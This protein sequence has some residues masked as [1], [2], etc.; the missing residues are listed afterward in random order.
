[1]FKKNQ[2]A[3]LIGATLASPMAYVN[4]QDVAVNATEVD[5]SMVVTGK[6]SSYKADSNTGSMRMEMT[7]LETPGQVTVID[8][9]LI[10]EQR[11]STLGQVLKND[12]SISAQ[13]NSRNRER[14]T[15]RGFELGS[16]SGFLRD[17]KQHWSHYRQPI[18]LLESVEVL[19]GPAG[20]LYGKS[21][22][23]GLINMV[24][25]KPTAETQM[26]FSQDIG[27]NNETRSTLDISGSLNESQSLRSRLVLS[28][29]D[30]ESSRS[31]SDGS[32]PKTDRFVGGLFVDYDLTDDIMLSVH[33]D[34]TIDDSSVDSGA[35]IKGGD[36]VLG[37]DYIWDAQ[38]SNIKNEVE[39]IGFDVA[40]DLS[41]NWS[42]NFS[43]NHQDFKRHD[44]ESYP[45][46]ES[47]DAATGTYQHSGNDRS[48]HWVF[49]TAN[50]DLI[51][52]FE[53]AGLDH[54]LLIGTNWLGYSYDMLRYSFN[55]ISTTVEQ[56]TASPEIN[57]AKD[58]R[59]YK[60]ESDSFGLYIQDMLT[61]NDQ[62]QVLAG[63]RYDQNIS[64]GQNGEEDYKE[65]AIVPK[66]AVIYHPASNGSIY[67][68]YSESFEPQGKVTNDKANNFDEK[69]D[70]KLGRLYELGSKWE[71]FD[72][73]LFA[74]GAI[75]EIT[76]ENSLITKDLGNDMVEVT[77]AGE[78]VHRG[79]E[80]AL[81]GYLT[82]SLSLSGSG[83]YL[84][85]EY[86]KDE[87]Y[88]GNRPADVPEF[89]ASIWSRYEFANN[90]DV[91]LGAIYVGSRFGDNANT[92]KKDA[93]T[94]FDLG[95]AHTLQYDQNLEFTVRL[96]V[97]NVFDTGYYAGGGSTGRG[98]G[99]YAKNG[100]QNVVLGEG[101]NFMATFQ[102]RY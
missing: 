15:L 13:G 24:S 32:S 10:N 5:E 86:T 72:E 88:Q 29:Q 75:F 47:Y 37:D 82:E 56:P 83:T 74:S 27:S 6:N 85:A 7:Q 26:E 77:Q 21:A 18:E 22:P 45:K 69:L 99:G 80:L 48:D 11:A 50:I 102:V 36:V 59:I 94:R 14:F 49:Q 40:A 52:E 43:F 38:W 20:L 78:R 17:G 55:P 71:L 3:L 34:K 63:L 67:V 79:A 9:Q 4:A 73:K 100:A 90:T 97:E 42:L 65:D 39:N 53:T 33:Y 44:V 101:R 35:Y 8:E 60:S 1:M 93:Y 46:E 87:N 16:S 84:D 41:T 23:G 12:S 25:K 57:T 68:T 51:G 76:Q 54:Q 19:K 92:F 98:D 89:S 28:K 95:V 2:L 62:W 58:P 61:I 81:Q 64:R 96:N 91:N 31:Y 66:M 70:P 30:S